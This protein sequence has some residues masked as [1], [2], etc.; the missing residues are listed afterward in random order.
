MFRLRQEFGIINKLEKQSM[1]N[2][3]LSNKK[4]I[5]L[6]EKHVTT[7]INDEKLPTSNADNI[8]NKFDCLYNSCN[9]ARCRNMNG[10]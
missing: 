3:I 4:N 1:S 10:N 8:Q 7:N 6:A 5:C 2:N 9:C